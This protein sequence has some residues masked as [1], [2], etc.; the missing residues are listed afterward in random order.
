MF[1]NI[2]KYNSDRLS[3]AKSCVI[4]T[5]V[6]MEIVL[7]LVLGPPAGNMRP[8]KGSEDGIDNPDRCYQAGKDDGR[9]SGFSQ[10][11]FDTCGSSYE[12]GFMRGYLSVDGNA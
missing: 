4:M 2:S 3:N 7:I 12:H 10:S 11:G 5:P 6:M 1:N 8:K 9:D